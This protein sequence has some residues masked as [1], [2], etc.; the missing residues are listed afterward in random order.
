[1]RIV[2]APNYFLMTLIR[3]SVTRGDGWPIWQNGDVSHVEIGDEI[4]THKECVEPLQCVKL[5]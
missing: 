3:V 5:S 4:I 2:L 1:L